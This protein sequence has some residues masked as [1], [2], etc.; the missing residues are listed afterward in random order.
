MASIF[1]S[2]LR[3][4]KPGKGDY[5]NNW[6]QPYNTLV[7]LIEEAV[8]GSASITATSGTV[9]LSTNNGA[10]DEARKQ[11]IYVNGALTGNLTVLVPNSQKR[12][13]V[14]NRTT[15]AFT[16]TVAPVGFPAGGI[17][18]AANR[19]GEVYADG[20][21]AVIFI[22]PPALPNGT[23]DPSTLPAAST[24]LAGVTRY[25]TP[26]EISTGTST[27][28]TMTTADIKAGLAAAGGTPGANSIAN[29]QLAQAPAGTLK[30]NLTGATA[31]EADNTLAAVGTA[32]AA[33]SAAMTNLTAGLP[34]M[35]ASGAAHA[36]GLVPDPGATAGTTK[37]LR[38]D[39][40][41]QAATPGTNSVT[42]AML[43]QAPANT[44]KANLTGAT[45][46]E[47]DATMLQLGTA[48]AADTTA[49]T[50]LANGIPVM[51]ASGAA[52]AK[53]LVPDPG[54]TAGTTRFL[55]EDGTWQTTAGGASQWTT[56]GSDIYYNAGN[57]GVGTTTPADKIEVAGGSLR[58][59]GGSTTN[60]IKFG[61]AVTVKN[62]TQALIRQQATNAADT[63]SYHLTPATDSPTGS[64]I[65]E[66]T[67]GAT[68]SQAF[69]G[70]YQRWSFTQLGTAYNNV[71]GIYGEFG[72]T[73]TP[74]EFI[75]N[76]GYESPPGTF[77][78]TEP[79]RLMVGANLGAV[80]F[81]LNQ[82]PRNAIQLT[83]INPTAA[84]TVDSHA[85]VMD[86]KAFDTSVHV[87]RWRVKVTATSNAGASRWDL[88]SKLD[89]AAE[90]TRLSVTDAGNVGVGTTSPVMK[91]HVAGISFSG[92]GIDYTAGIDP[93]NN[94]IGNGSL[95]FG[96]TQNNSYPIVQAS[97]NLPINVN[98][99]GFSGFNMGS[100]ATISAPVHATASSA[101]PAVSVNGRA[102]DNSAE[103]NFY[104]NTGA[105][106]YA[107]TLVSPTEYRQASN[108]AVISTWYTGGAER[109]RLDSTGNLGVG[110]TAPGSKLD[111][112]G[113]VRLS[114]ATSGFVGLA[115]AAAAG[116][117]TYTLPSADGTAGQVLST[118][119]AATLSWQTAP[120]Q[121][122]NTDRKSTRL[123]SSHRT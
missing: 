100:T 119:G 59:P 30:G 62:E 17:T 113:T 82:A 95:L 64:T 108:G 116:S 73:R 80:G 9:T 8:A 45:A 79:M 87:N 85:I 86:A 24:T 55:R 104:D 102:A 122:N 60:G 18:L 61:T 58:V 67:I 41:W 23:I 70:N 111:V 101:G 4:E 37:F 21:G 123:N 14:V 28:T 117:T 49:I 81:S 5:L 76:Y 48:L 20:S 53:G 105:T 78:S 110:T 65:S 90:G 16:T 107:K 51:G 10:T 121:T 83:P 19:M 77:T 84:G 34:V 2:L 52:H 71:A 68:A 13:T 26:A 22:S 3:L 47:T 31:N 40:T 50:T 72:G 43:A 91:L 75:W 54:A 11:V 88:L 25:A 97:S 33:D 44:V 99:T 1:T 46:N 98:P 39:A 112:K 94:A 36:K 114:G 96:K 57:V 35:G 32:L 118:D 42:N 27:T 15:G 106:N 92:S 74:T 6:Q 12:Y 66:V 56:N 120:T 38:E 115:P 89:G 7:D 29:S 109:V 103:V 69:G 63:A 93:A